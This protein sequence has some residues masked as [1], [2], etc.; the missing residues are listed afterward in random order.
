M[1]IYGTGSAIQQGLSAATAAIQ[2]LAGGDIKAALAGGVSPYLAEFIEKIVP[3]ESSRVMAH[4]VLGAV[5]AELAGGNALAGASGAGISAA[6]AKYIKTQLYGDRRVD[7]LT[8]QEKQTV[9][10]LAG[11]LA[12]GIVGGD[13]SSAMDGGKI[14]WL[15]LN[16]A[17]LMPK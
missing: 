12:G 13:K 16:M 9:T 4:I 3:D 8:E 2:G 1:A 17:I 7:Q 5:S 14:S 6:G 15:P 10:A 11:G